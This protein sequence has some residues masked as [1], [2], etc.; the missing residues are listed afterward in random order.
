MAR[1]Q[2]ESGIDVVSRNGRQQY[3][4]PDS[5]II[6]TKEQYREGTLDQKFYVRQGKSF[7]EISP[8]YYQKDTTTKYIYFDRIETIT[9]ASIT[10]KTQGYFV[11]L[12]FVG[13][14][15]DSSSNKRRVFFENHVRQLIGCFP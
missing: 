3:M 5:G 2:Y 14:K 9:C 13:T 7:S 1:W 8:Y 6:L 10:Q 4:V 15:M 11:K 12:F